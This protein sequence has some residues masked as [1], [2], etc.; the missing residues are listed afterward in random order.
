V[1]VALDGFVDHR[2]VFLGQRAWDAGTEGTAAQSTDD[3]ASDVMH[4]LN[5]RVTKC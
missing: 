3:R 1:P 4:A 5:V 2:L